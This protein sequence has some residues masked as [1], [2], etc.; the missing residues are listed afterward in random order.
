MGQ[1]NCQTI[2]R[3]TVDDIIK[4]YDN[5]IVK[6]LSSKGAD[7]DTVILYAAQQSNEIQRKLAGLDH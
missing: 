2:K 3:T 6:L 1:I 7:R 5:S 4:K